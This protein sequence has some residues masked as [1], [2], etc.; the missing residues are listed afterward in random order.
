MKR[1]GHIRLATLSILGFAAC[2]TR[3]AA[4]PDPCRPETYND[5]ACQ[6]A[7]KNHGYYSNGSFIYGNYTQPYLSYYQRYQAYTVQGGVSHPASAGSYSAQGGGGG[8]EAEGEVSR[9]G[10]GESAQAAGE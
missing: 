6:D 3:Q 5:I 8:G 4:L 10:F 2:S 1:S 7:V 9:G